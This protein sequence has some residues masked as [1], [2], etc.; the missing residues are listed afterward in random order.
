MNTCK[1]VELSNK[2]TKTIL[3]LYDEKTK[4]GVINY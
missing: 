1:N 3:D 4:T 2:T